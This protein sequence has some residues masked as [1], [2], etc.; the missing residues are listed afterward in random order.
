[1]GQQDYSCP[2]NNQWTHLSKGK[3]LEKT[4]GR[5]DPEEFYFKIVLKFEMYGV[6]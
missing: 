3:V 2:Y 5:E 4:A 6:D 1:M